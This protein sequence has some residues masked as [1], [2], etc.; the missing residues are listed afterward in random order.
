MHNYVPDSYNLGPSPPCATR[1]RCDRVFYPGTGKNVHLHARCRHVDGIERLE[2][3][4]QLKRTDQSDIYFSAT[5]S[6]Y[7]FVVHCKQFLV[8]IHTKTPWPSVGRGA[9]SSMH[10]LELLI[11]RL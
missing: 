10:K 9:G 11:L 2:S 1:E 7:I 6:L 8:S 3:K 4:P 5:F